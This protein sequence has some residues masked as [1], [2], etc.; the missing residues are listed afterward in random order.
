MLHV[1][2]KAAPPYKVH[3][4]LFAWPA[5]GREAVVDPDAT[6][7]VEEAGKPVV[8]TSKSYE[9]LKRES[10]KALIIEPHG[11]SDTASMAVKIAD[12]EDDLRGAVEH[13]RKLEV[14]IERLMMERDEARRSADAADEKAS[15]ARAATVKAEAALQ[16]L[17][18]KQ[19]ADPAPV[20]DEKKKGK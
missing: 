1:L 8:L 11:Q 13:I 3:H 15:A 9:Y 4:R 19:A 16:A 18:V 6:K 14:S 5:A 2:I 7:D 12:L 10:G 20:T 17:Q